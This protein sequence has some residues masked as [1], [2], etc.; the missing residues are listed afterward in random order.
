ML[1]KFVL[2]VAK[3]CDDSNHYKDVSPLRLFE[4]MN[5]INFLK[6]SGAGQVNHDKG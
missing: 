3:K 4:I 2:G 1:G 5:H 6:L